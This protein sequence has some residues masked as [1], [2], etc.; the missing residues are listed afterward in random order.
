MLAPLLLCVE[1]LTHS[2][3]MIQRYVDELRAYL[4]AHPRAA[5]TV[6]GVAGFWLN[7]P[8]AHLDEKAALEAALE[9]LVAEGMVMRR[10]GADG[11]VIFAGMGG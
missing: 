1:W 9:Q 6:V 8:P 2:E 11:N 5:D 4:T 7:T 10:T 3:S